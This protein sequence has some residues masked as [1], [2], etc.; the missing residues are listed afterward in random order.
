MASRSP[1]LFCN[2][3]VSSLQWA[4]VSTLFSHTHFRAF[5]AVMADVIKQINTTIPAL[6]TVSFRQDSAGCYH[7][8]ACRATIVCAGVLGAEG[9]WCSNS[10]LP[11]LPMEGREPA[12][13]RPAETKSDTFVLL[14]SGHDIKI[15]VEN[16]P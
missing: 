15:P 14:N 2:T 11:S 10:W 8:R 3:S 16:H 4:L 6:K 5:L 7:C 12:T 1:K 13:A 9:A